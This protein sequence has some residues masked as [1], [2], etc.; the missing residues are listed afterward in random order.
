MFW[1]GL[2]WLV[3]SRVAQPPSPYLSLVRWI[4]KPHHVRNVGGI[5]DHQ[6][7]RDFPEAHAV[8]TM[9][10]VQSTS[11]ISINH[12]QGSFPVGMLGNYDSGNG[13]PRNAIVTCTSFRWTRKT[14]TQSAPKFTYLRSKIDIYPSPTQ[15][16]IMFGCALTKPCRIFEN[17][18]TATSSVVVL[19]E[20][21]CPRGP[22]FKSLSLSSSSNHKSLSL[23]SAVQVLENRQGLVACTLWEGF[24]LTSDFGPCWTRVQHQGTVHAATLCTHGQQTAEWVYDDK[25]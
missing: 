25:G 9:S 15:S 2:L 14:S 1:A 11:N 18:I 7:L 23:S 10:K 17:L 21:P 8:K 5:A 22:I 3:V 6:I 16:L 4:F 24:L 13:D 12:Q 19:E 20:S